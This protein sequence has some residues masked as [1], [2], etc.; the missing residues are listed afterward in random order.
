[1]SEEQKQYLL[2][3][4]KNLHRED[5]STMVEQLDNINVDVAYV[6]GASVPSKSTKTS[7]INDAELHRILAVIRAN[8]DAT[9]FQNKDLSPLVQ[10]LTARQVPS[11][12]KKLVDAG[13][14]TDLGGSPKKY[15]LN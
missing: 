7:K 14:L 4:I 15:I 11:R 13:H 8:F 9:E 1:M 5:V 3:N 12:I 10:G 2:D 6:P